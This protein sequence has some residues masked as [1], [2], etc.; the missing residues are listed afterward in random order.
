MKNQVVTKDG[1]VVVRL[2]IGYKAKYID[3][4]NR[5]GLNQSEFLMYLLENYEGDKLEVLQNYRYKIASRIK[6][7]I[8]IL[9]INELKKIKD[10]IDPVLSRL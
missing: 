9:Y 2:P 7:G 6:K 4:M 8:N 5:T 1:R 3:G 10:M